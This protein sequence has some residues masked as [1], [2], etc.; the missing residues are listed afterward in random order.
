VSNP[1]SLFTNFHFF[2]FVVSGHDFISLMVGF[3]S[4][5][6]SNWF[7]VF[8]LRFDFWVWVWVC[9]CFAILDCYWYC[10]FMLMM[11]DSNNSA[12]LCSGLDEFGDEFLGCVHMTMNM[13]MRCLIFFRKKIWEKKASFRLLTLFTPFP[14]SWNV[15]RI[16][17]D[18]IG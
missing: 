8:C 4:W 5:W 7:F 13:K 2:F 17:V 9:V 12:F 1:G 15:C 10:L 6:E 14:L 16:Y 18:K 11:K 3:L